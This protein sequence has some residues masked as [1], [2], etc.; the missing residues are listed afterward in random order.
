[1]KLWD[2]LVIAA[3]VALL[4]WNYIDRKR[5]AKKRRLDPPLPVKAYEFGNP[6][7]IVDLGLVSEIRAVDLFNERFAYAD[8]VFDDAEEAIAKTAIGFSRDDEDYIEFS[9][10]RTSLIN[11]R[12]GIGVVEAG[13]EEQVDLGYVDD[14]RSM[15]RAYFQ[16]PRDFGEYWRNQEGRKQAP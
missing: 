13:S 15:I 8:V 7:E 4:A 12:A 5:R 6:F 11:V 1:M 3:V 14:A 9:V 10:M 2:W 16:R